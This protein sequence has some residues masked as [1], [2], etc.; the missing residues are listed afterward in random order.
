MACPTC[1]GECCCASSDPSPGR[2]RT[3]VLIDPETYDASEEQF[4]SSLAERVTPVDVATELEAAARASRSQ[5]AASGADWRNEVASRVTRYR[6]RRGRRRPE[7]PRSL[8]FNFE[9]PQAS[10]SVAPGATAAP[11][12]EF[13][14]ED[15]AGYDTPMSQQVDAYGLMRSY[16]R[17]RAAQAAAQE[18]I[19]ASRAALAPGAE[20][21]PPSPNVIE[22]PRTPLA[23]AAAPHLAEELAEPIPAQ[24]RI[25]EVEEV[26]EAE[27]RETAESESEQVMEDTRPASIMLGP[28]SIESDHSPY[29]EDDEIPLLVAPLLQRS[30]AGLLDA[31]AAGS[32]T[33]LF[34]VIVSAM[35]AWPDGRLGQALL[36][37]SFALFWAVYQYLFLVHNGRTL[38]MQATGLGL[39]TFDGDPLTRRQRRAR[40]IAMMVSL[41]SMGLGFLWAALDEDTLAWHDR[42]TRS[43]LTVPR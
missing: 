41:M 39:A 20:P 2:A 4:A 3:S 37:L 10:S 9:E 30:L 26:R 7:R 8:T 40:A 5:D 18:L 35:N 31:F 22:F 23:L 15:V 27:A 38:G 17:S 1:V 36:P 33:V 12:V 19:E 6:A 11:H 21:Q 32:G 14:R 28:S 25:F 34:A 43:C 24:P 16:P 42:I 13:V 29:V